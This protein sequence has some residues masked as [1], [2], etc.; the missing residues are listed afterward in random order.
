M[1]V[2]TDH[3]EQEI[4]EVIRCYNLWR[5][6]IVK[7]VEKRNEFHKTEEGKQKNRANSKNYYQRHREE[8]LEKRR[9]KY[10]SRQ[11]PENH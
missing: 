9:I 11:T 6:L 10:A 4:E 2:Q 3:G 8:I 5:N 7:N 1:K